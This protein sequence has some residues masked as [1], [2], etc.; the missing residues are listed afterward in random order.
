MAYTGL[1]GRSHPGSAVLALGLAALASPVD[2]QT[3]SDVPSGSL[4]ISRAVPARA[5]QANEPA[6]TPS[7][8]RLDQSAL[9]N[10][11]VGLGL[12]P[13]ADQEISGVSAGPGRALPVQ[14]LIAPEGASLAAIPSQIT[15]T[16]NQLLSSPVPGTAAMIGTPLQA[17]SQ[18][19]SALSS[20]LGGGH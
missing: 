13:L 6:G 17:I 2:A 3:R 11:A 4:I 10:G 19:M 20:A 9:I 16:S 15:S 12:A 18:A 8:V 14:A 5:A 7:Y 1:N